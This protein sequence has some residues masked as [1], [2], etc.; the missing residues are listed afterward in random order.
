MSPPET[1]ME[2]KMELM[3]RA[4]RQFLLYAKTKP[5]TNA[6]KKLT[7]RGTFSDI[8]CWTKSRMYAVGISIRQEWGE[9]RTGICLYASGYLTGTN[10]IKK[11]NILAK[12]GPQISLANPLS[13]HLG[14][15]D[16]HTHVNVSADEHTHACRGSIT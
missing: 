16:P 10:L 14:S 13:S 11:G 2:G 12:D 7:T 6:E 1:A 3:A 9:P 4:S 15:V 5:V 8:P